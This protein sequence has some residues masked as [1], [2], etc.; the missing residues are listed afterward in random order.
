MCKVRDY[1]KDQLGGVGPRFVGI[2]ANKDPAA[3]KYAEWT[4]RA[5]VKDGIRY[6]VRAVWSTVTVRDDAF[7]FVFTVSSRA[8]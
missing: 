1:I 5:C 4:N 3:R 8:A 2:L 7:F 6:E